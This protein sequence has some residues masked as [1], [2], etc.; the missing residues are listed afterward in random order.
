MRALFV[1]VASALWLSGGAAWA[2]H[3]SNN[4]TAVGE[5]GPLIPFHKD[6][7][8][9]GL[10]ATGDGDL[11]ICF[12]MRPSEYAGHH[13]VDDTHITQLFNQGVPLTEAM[14]P[15][16]EALVYGSGFESDVN[17]GFFGYTYSTRTHGLDRSVATRIKAD[18][19]LDNGL[20]LDLGDPDAFKNN[21]KFDVAA[22]NAS[23]A[24]LNKHAFSNAGDTGGLNYNI[25]CSGNVALA[26][27]R[28]LF[29]GGHDKTGPAGIAK[30]LL[31]DPETQ[32]WADRGLPP[33]KEDFLDDPEGLTPF[34]ANPLDEDNTDPPHPSDMKYQRWYP[35]GVV[36]PDGRVLILSGTDVDTRLG[37]S[38]TTCT[39]RTTHAN[40]SKV[41]QATP[42]VYDPVSDTTIALENARKLFN[43]Y[44]HA[45][46]VKTGKGENDWKVAVTGEVDEDFLAEDG[47]PPL[48]NMNTYDPWTYNGN[49]YYLD[50]LGALN[51]PKL[52]KPAEKHWKFVD[53]AEIAHNSGAGAQLWVLDDK[54]EAISQTV[55][56]FGGGCGRTGGLPVECDR[57]T[58]EM[59]DFQAKKPQWERQEDIIKV[60]TGNNAT[61]LPDGKVLIAGG[62]TGRGPWNNTFEL[63]LFDPASGTI[64]PMVHGAL[65]RHDHSTI[66]LLPDGSVAIMGGNRTDVANN[67]SLDSS[68][69]G[70]DIGVPATEIYKPPY[71][72]NGPPPVI[73]AAPDDISY[74]NSF[75][76][77]VSGGSGDIGSVVIIRMGPVSHNWDWGNR[78]VKLHFEEEDDMLHVTAPAGP[79]LAIPG[80]YLLFVVSDQGVPGEAKVVHVDGA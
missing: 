31:F 4:P 70:V 35:T 58:V 22:L 12:F 73:E 62:S 71:F 15:E 28:W 76:I 79:A 20:C 59:I 14:K 2:I 24:A 68:P 42:E 54:G 17:P 74:G 25:F 37:R 48:E 40:C 13:L 57:Q 10:A 47:L 64:T 30:L 65:P 33:V 55:V 8:H 61:P 63:Q 27:G 34:H 45:Y 66:A 51:D 3:P 41:R 5:I 44:T 72:F 77:E 29:I 32:T 46:V 67:P 26:D 23:D 19:G 50:V 11:K 16:F 53:T 56:L 43:M 39:S 52:D 80:D 49:T 1:G 78:Y 75:D 60:A 9:A 21:G 69:V 38:R 6:A 7:I 18:I 36:L